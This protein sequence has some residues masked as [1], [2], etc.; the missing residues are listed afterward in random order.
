MN[1]MF[2]DFIKKNNENTNEPK[3]VNL[4]ELIKNMQKSNSEKPKN[5]VNLKEFLKIGEKKND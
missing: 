4:L 5:P 2:L 3:K 1:N